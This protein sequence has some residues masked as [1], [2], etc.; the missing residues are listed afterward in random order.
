MVSLTLS[1]SHLTLRGAIRDLS[2]A[3]ETWFS[4]YEAVAERI[5]LTEPPPLAPA[6]MVMLFW[7]LEWNFVEGVM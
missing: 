2:A 3:T 6:S 4:D 5:G 1:H 7:F